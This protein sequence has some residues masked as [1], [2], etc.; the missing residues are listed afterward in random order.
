M[1]ILKNEATAVLGLKQAEVRTYSKFHKNVF[2]PVKG[3]VSWFIVEDGNKKYVL[4]GN[5]RKLKCLM[6][7]SETGYL[8]SLLTSQ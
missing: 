3:K 2:D 7:I 4:H 8:S 6:P 1:K 5:L